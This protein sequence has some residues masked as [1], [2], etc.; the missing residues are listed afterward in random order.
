MAARIKEKQEV[1]VGKVDVAELRKSLNSKLKGAVF[2]LNKENPTDVKE[3]IS[4]GS[5]WLDAIVAKGKMGGIPV[6]KIVELA[7]L[8]A[9]VTEDTEIEVIIE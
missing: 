7:G 1:K 8:Q 3:W 9:C 6:G 2:D 5:T 4:T